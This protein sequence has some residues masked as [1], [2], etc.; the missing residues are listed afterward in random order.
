MLQVESNIQE[1]FDLIDEQLTI[2]EMI[3]VKN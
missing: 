1:L 2:L 3:E